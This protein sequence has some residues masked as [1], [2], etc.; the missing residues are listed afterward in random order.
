[1]HTKTKK[2]YNEK[3]KNITENKKYVCFKKHDFA[4]HFLVL[5]WIAYVVRS[6][7][8]KRETV[9]ETLYQDNNNGN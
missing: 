2:K 1:M 3:M 8:K 4:T 9:I 6:W 5:I 7:G